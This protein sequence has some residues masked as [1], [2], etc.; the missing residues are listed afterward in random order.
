MRAR[1][2]VHV[3][4]SLCL[5]LFV[6]V[7]FAGGVAGLFSFLFLHPIDVMKSLHQSI[8]AGSGATLSSVARE[9]YKKDGFRFLTRGLVPTCVRAFPVSAIIFVVQE[10]LVKLLARVN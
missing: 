6:S 9:C 2:H 4:I 5:S 8:V 10:E 7:Q 1:M 3:S